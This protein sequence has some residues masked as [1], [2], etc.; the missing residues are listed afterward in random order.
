MGYCTKSTKAIENIEL[1]LYL[2]K[3]RKGVSSVKREIKRLSL[4]Y[5][6]CSSYLEIVAH[7]S[8][9]PSK[10]LSNISDKPPVLHFKPYYTFAQVL[11]QQIDNF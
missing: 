1:R 10:I 9:R 3:L 5:S 4:T 7:F 8:T 11:C 6:L 2:D